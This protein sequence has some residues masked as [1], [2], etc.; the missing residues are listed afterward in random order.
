MKP[1]PL[2]RFLSHAAALWLCQSACAEAFDSGSRGEDGD[3]EVA[4]NALVVIP[5]RANGV[6]KYGT[7]RIHTGAQVRFERNDA[8]TPIHLLATG[9]VLIEGTVNVSGEAGGTFDGGRGGPGGFD[10]G[11]P[12]IA[13]KPP[14][15]GY[16]PGG[17][18][19]GA[20]NGATEG[21]GGGGYGTRSSAGS[22][23]NR[24][25]TYGTELLLP[26]LGGS[27]GGGQPDLGGGGGGGAILVA[28]TTRIE[29]RSLG[30]IVANGAQTPG[31]GFGSGGAVRLVAPE[32]AGTGSVSAIG[33]NF[34]GDGRI[35]VD[36]VRR[37][38]LALHFFPSAP[39][40]LVVGSLMAVFPPVTAQLD[41]VRVGTETIV[42]GTGIP[43]VI[44]L[45]LGASENQTIEVRARDFNQML[46][47]TVAL[48]PDSGPPSFFHV[49]LDNT[50]GHNPNTQPVS[51]NIPA[52]VLVRV[53]AWTQ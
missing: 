45:P 7:I 15:A 43:V 48:I 47:V 18:N 23:V 52:N 6:F 21:A 5:K 9:D 10:G 1:F 20:G 32:V 39:G 38:A 33:Y 42:P 16:G 49:P 40:T 24:G 11:R 28:S 13:G 8:N 46:D 29:I 4:S 31:W 36:L 12:G 25:A 26:L 27:G 44:K 22:A 51:V 50:A 41:I 34:A 35:R 19:G 53:M 2:L 14:G 17:G 37:D 30:R 3:L